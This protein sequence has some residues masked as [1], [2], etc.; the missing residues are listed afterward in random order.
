M[1]YLSL[2]NISA[3]LV[4]E[5][6]TYDFSSVNFT[7]FSKEMIKEIQDDCI[8]FLHYSLDKDFE[9]IEGSQFGNTNKYYI[10]KIQD[11]INVQ[12][13]PYGRSALAYQ[14]G[15]YFFKE[16]NGTS[17]VIPYHHPMD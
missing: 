9:E 6:T 10:T 12:V 7:G 5:M 4:I 1:R 2:T 14:Y 13:A 11:D 8:R 17:K 15:I 3:P 16:K